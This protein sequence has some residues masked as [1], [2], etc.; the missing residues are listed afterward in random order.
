MSAATALAARAAVEP[1]CAGPLTAA[2]AGRLA[3]AG[4]ESAR[5]DARLL[6][7]QAF[8][9][10]AAHL[11]AHP[12]WRPAPAMRRRFETLVERRQRREPVALIL[13]R[14]EFW[15]LDFQVT[16]ATLVPRPE[17]ETVVERALAGVADRDADI[18]V[19]DLGTGSGCL[20][21]AL[22]SELP[23]ARG[24]G[25]DISAAAL[26]LARA[27]ADAL[28]LGSRAH[29]RKSDWGGA[30][31]E[32]FDLVV[33]NPPY[34][35]DGDFAALAPD[36]SRFEPRRALSGGADGLD[37]YRA[38]VPGLTRLLN[39]GSRVVLEIGAGQADAVTAMLKAQRL[40]VS[41]VHDDLA[42]RPRAIAACAEF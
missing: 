23:R 1:D 12:E 7:A 17:T 18:S 33:A 31:T 19:L 16:A 22:L 5:L 35:A 38:M 15:G 26:E 11:L 25:V 32:T 3:D 20:L 41:G 21:L 30:V 8:G 42:A 14:R 24:L 9:V 27:N 37:A 6:A 4:I 36:V 13:G 10:D 40:A 2:A 34:I 29:F 28:G 39:P